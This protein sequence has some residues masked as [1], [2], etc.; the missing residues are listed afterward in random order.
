MELKYILEAI[1]F[2]AQ[3]PLTPK[4]QRDLLVAAAQH[5]DEAKPF[6]KTKENDIETAL[7]QLRD[8]HENRR[9]A[10][11]GS[12]APLARGNSS[13]SPNT[14]LGS[15]R[16]LERKPVRRDS[17]SPRWKPSPSSR[18]AQPITRAEI[19]QVRGVAIDGV[20]QTLQER[21][22]VDQAG[23]AEVAGR[24]MTYG[25]SALFLEYF[26]L[27]RSGRFT[28]RRRIGRRI[29]VTPVP[30][31]LLTADPGLATVAAPTN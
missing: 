5:G 16:W 28:R 17:R 22:L 13:A 7:E 6:K 25:T 2:S 15:G 31:R 12:P 14:R 1:L 20:M 9:R 27:R 30:K 26:G 8:D 4:E 3:K 21:G 10:V 29:P 23:R 24:P 11:T 18:I 19:E